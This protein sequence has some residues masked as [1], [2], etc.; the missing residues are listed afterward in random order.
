LRDQLDGKLHP[1]ALDRDAW[2]AYAV[3]REMKDPKV[4]A[5][6]AGALLSL[7][8]A[9]LLAKFTPTS[10]YMVLAKDIPLEIAD[11]LRTARIPGIGVSKIQVRSYPE[12]AIG[13]QF[14]GFVVTD[15]Q[16][17]R[18][19][20]YG[21]EANQNTLL[22]GEYGSI[23]GEKDAAGRLLTTA[24]LEL[25]PSQN[26][27]DLVLTID[28]TVQFTVCRTIA[29]AVQQFQAD[30]GSVIVVDPKTGGIISM[31]S[32]PDFDPAN[33]GSVKDLGDL[34]NP[35][36]FASYEP[37]SIFKPIT[38]AAGLNEG[39]ITPQSTYNDTGEE[40]MDDFTIRNSDKLG[41]GVQTMTEVLAKSLNTGT[42]YVQRLL[43]K[44]V[45]RDYVKKFGFG[46]RLGVELAQ[47]AKGNISSLDKKGKIFAATASFGQ[48]ITT[49]PLQMVMSYAALANG[50]KLLK[51]HIVAEIVRPDG[52]HELVKPEVLETVVSKNTSRLISAMMV[53]VV[54]NGHGKRAA[55]PGYYVAGKTGTAQVPDPRGAGYLKD[56]TIGSFAGY[57]PA[58][59]PRFVMLV[60][61]DRP[62]TVQYAEASAAPVFGELAKFLLNYY[63]IPPERPIE[64][65]DVLP[66]LASMASSTSLGGMA[67]D[68]VAPI[69]KVKTVK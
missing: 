36:V 28:R 14:L 34:N 18:V 53:D 25:K 20:R 68:G 10:T 16:N 43:G 58:Q 5:R 57:A 4:S 22:T 19:G 29:S 27:S 64:K 45:F 56:V 15:D 63:Q 31:C 11:K 60:R 12:H 21:V 61:M 38:L 55:V 39:K 6:E 7:P 32:T 17:R 69:T 30:S 37:G 65:R 41:H 40:T 44:D 13:G 59:N 52:T 50:G 47:E 42:I 1:I 23:V 49:T 9:D 51:P 48:G 24:S 26:G 67:P 46:E 2:Q 66:N 8:E 54:E 3:P 33:Y 35:A 62:K